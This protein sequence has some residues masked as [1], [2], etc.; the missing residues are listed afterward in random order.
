M[1][2]IRNADGRGVMFEITDLERTL[3]LPSL[4]VRILNP[5]RAAFVDALPDDGDVF[6]ALEAALVDRLGLVG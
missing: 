6:D 2:S 4:R 3:P 5:A 1:H